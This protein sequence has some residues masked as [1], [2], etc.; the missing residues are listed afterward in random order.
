MFINIVSKTQN[1]FLIMKNSNYVI[2]KKL[3]KSMGYIEWRIQAAESG[4]V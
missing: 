1:A 4:S 2:K 3:W